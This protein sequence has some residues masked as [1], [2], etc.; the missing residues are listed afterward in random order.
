ML[1]CFYFN[2][3]ITW[4]EMPINIFL[5]KVNKQ[6]ITLITGIIIMNSKLHKNNVM[7]GPQVIIFFDKKHPE[8]KH[9]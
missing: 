5:Q 7:T 4:N 1:M 3:E 8:I 2:T 6:V 9:L